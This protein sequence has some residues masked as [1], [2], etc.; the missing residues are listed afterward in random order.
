[1][2]VSQLKLNKKNPRKISPQQMEKLK[3]SIEKFPKMMSLRPIVYDPDTMEVLG[4]NQRLLAIRAL[5]MKEIPDDWVKSADELTEKE[6]REFIIRDNIQAGDWDFEILEAEF[7][8]FLDSIEEMGLDFPKML[9]IEIEK[10]D[11]EPQ[12]D[13]VAELQKK[14]QTKFGQIW[15]CGRHRVM[16]GDSTNEEQVK[17]LLDGHKPGLMVTDPPYGV[18]YDPKW[19]EGSGL[20]RK[21]IAGNKITNDDNADWTKAWVLSPSDVCYVYHA[22]IKTVEVYNSLL[23]AGYEPI[24]LIIW[25]KNTIVIGRGDYHHKHDPIWY[26]HRKGKPHSWAG[27]R[28]ESTVWDIDKNQKNSTGHSTQKP[29]ECMQKP[30]ENH[31]HKEV[32]DPFLGSG[33]TLIA[34]ENT[35]RTCF[36]ME[37]DPGYVAV[38]LQRYH[39]HTGNTPEIINV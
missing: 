30:I 24:N 12:V 35:N 20:N 14:W 18:E 9:D 38:T 32:Y 10:K 6:K 29:L 19:R 22:Q 2:K 17:Q 23:K 11:T 4:G 16:C 37:I 15:K 25:N 21:G 36:G 39:D 27:S 26:M 31:T 33:T 13:K 1:M 28:K 34:C 3:A 5:G 8:E 7:S